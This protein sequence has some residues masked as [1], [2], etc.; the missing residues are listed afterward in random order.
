M[1]RVLAQSRGTQAVLDALTTPNGL[2]WVLS[3]D[4][5]NK[6]V[7]LFDGTTLGGIALA[8]AADTFTLGST[9]IALGSTTTTVTGLTLSGGTL[10]GT[11]AVPSGGGG[12]SLSSAGVLTLSLNTAAVQAPPASTVLHLGGVN[13]TSPRSLLD[14]YGNFPQIVLRRANTSAAAPSAI[15]LNDALGVISAFGYGATAYSTGRASIFFGAA[16]AWNDTAQGTYFAFSVTPIGGTTASPALFIGSAGKIGIGTGT[17]ASQPA[18]TLS[19]GGAAATAYTS[20]LDTDASNYERAYIGDWG[21]T[22]NVATFGPTKLGTGTYRVGRWVSGG[23]TIWDSLING[24]FRI[25]TGSAIA[26]NATGGF[27]KIATCAGTPTGAPANA[28]TGSA[29]LVYDSTGKKFWI[30]DNATT[31]WKGVV[32]A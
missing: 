23:V 9:S 24:D 25:G 5:T 17:A 26:T 14:G 4:T 8:K 28:A 15:A 18:A 31:S 30:Y 12:A 7:R 27:V 6:R 32:V 22:A 11:T 10:S 13:G 29:E 19:I 21:A 20:N 1:A 2:S 16:E 3:V